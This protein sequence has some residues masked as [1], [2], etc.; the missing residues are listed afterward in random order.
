MFDCRPK[1]DLSAMVYLHFI[2]TQAVTLI[3]TG[4]A[5][6]VVTCALASKLNLSVLLSETPSLTVVNNSTVTV[7]GKAVIPIPVSCGNSVHVHA[8]VVSTLS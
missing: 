2:T 8:I 4:A 1:H 5:V 3:D 6:T 7:S